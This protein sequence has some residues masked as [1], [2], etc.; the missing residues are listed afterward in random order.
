MEIRDQIQRQ[1]LCYEVS[2]CH[3]VTVEE[4]EDQ[5]TH[6]KRVLAGFDVDLN[7]TGAAGP[8]RLRTGYQQFQSTLKDLEKVARAVVPPVADGSNIA[9]L[10][11]EDSLVIDTRRSL[12]GVP[13]NEPPIGGSSRGIPCRKNR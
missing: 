5:F 2:P 1:K 9:I 4:P 3:R 7:A 8:W 13:E 6:R 12:H 11:F 10:P